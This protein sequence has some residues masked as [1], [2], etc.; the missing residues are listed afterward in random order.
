MYRT[1]FFFSIPPGYKSFVLCTAIE[2]GTT[3]DFDFIYNHYQK[4]TDINQK[5]ELIYAL[6]CSRKSWLL[7]KLLGELLSNGNDFFDALKNVASKSNGYLLA[8]SFTK[9]NFYQIFEKFSFKLT[10]FLFYNK[11]ILDKKNI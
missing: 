3:A 6:S 1:C 11:I 2:H 9:N 8:F 4:T 5:K 7:I 10:G